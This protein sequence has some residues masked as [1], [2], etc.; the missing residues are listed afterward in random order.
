MIWQRKNEICPFVCR[1]AKRC[2]ALSW[3]SRPKAV[4]NHSRPRN[5]RSVIHVT[6]C[7][8]TLCDYSCSLNIFHD[9]CL[10]L[11]QG[12]AILI[13]EIELA[14]KQNYGFN[15]STHEKKQFKFMR[16]GAG[17]GGWA[18]RGNIPDGGSIHSYQHKSGQLVRRDIY[19]HER[20][21][22]GQFKCA[23]FIR[24][25]SHQL[26][27]HRTRGCRCCRHRQPHSLWD[28]RC[29]YRMDPR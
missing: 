4:K 25:G 1:P 23:Q 21:F 24:C 20:Q 15:L 22:P 6:I 26:L 8:Q 10:T 7:R 27:H 3:L 12:F 17:F 9:F 13:L 28:N 18:I 19:R 5:R 29:L 14:N 11:F 2:A 16:I